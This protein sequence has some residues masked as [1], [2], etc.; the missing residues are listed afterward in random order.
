V[1]F[2]KCSNFVTSVEKSSGDVFAKRPISFE[3]LFAEELIS[4]ALVR[5]ARI[6]PSRFGQCCRS[7][8]SAPA[9]H[10]IRRAW[11]RRGF[12]FNG[13][14]RPPTALHWSLRAR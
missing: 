13:G 2:G 8:Y 14:S 3:L 12:V 5:K 6:G 9:I 10:A 1:I 7:K 4:R 11:T